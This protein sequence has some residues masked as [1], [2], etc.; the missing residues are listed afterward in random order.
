M[1]KIIFT[2]LDGTLLDVKYSY[3]EALPALNKIKEIPLIFSSSKTRA[4]IEYQRK[5]LKN[6]HPFISENGGAIFIPDNYFDFKFDYDKSDKKYKIIE[7]GTTIN[8]INNIIEK[9]KTK[10]IKIRSFDD[11]SSAEISKDSNLPLKLAKLAKKREYDMP[12]KIFNGGDAPKIKQMVEKAGLTFIKGIRYSHITGKNNKGKAVRTLISIYKRKYGEIKTI[13]LGDSKN[14]IPML[15]NVDIPVL[16]KRPDN[17]YVNF[18]TKNL[19][20]SNLIGPA[21]WNEAVF[22]IM[23]LE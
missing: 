5:R 4:E 22:K 19:I 13:A 2:D 7:H 14:D 15:K 9:I 16:I 20:K 3:K 10:G 17:S 21:G 6:V 8:K 11:M 12:I 18:K 1:Y 23:K